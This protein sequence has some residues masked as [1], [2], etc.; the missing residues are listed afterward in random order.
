MKALSRFLA[1]FSLAF[2]VGFSGLIAC[3]SGTNASI[4]TL[5]L[6]ITGAG[7][8][9]IT[10]NTGGIDCSSSESSCTADFEENTLVTLTATPEAGYIFKGWSGANCSGAGTCE[11]TMS[12]AT[13]INAVFTMVLF[14]SNT[15]LNGDPTDTP[16]PYNIWTMKTDGSNLQHVT[17]VTA[18]GVAADFPV[19]SP[20]GEQIVF[21]SNY[22]LDNPTSGTINVAYNIWTV[23]NDGSNLSPLTLSTT[24]FANA[25]KPEWSPDGEQITF[26]ASFN[27]DNPSS[28]TINDS[29]NIWVINSDGSEL[30]HLTNTDLTGADANRP[31]WSPDGGQIVFDATFNLS[32][33]VSGTPNSDSNIW[34]VNN[35]GNSLSALTTINISGAE[36]FEPQWSPDGT[37]IIFSSN[38]NLSAPT[39]GSPNAGTNIWIMDADGSS[40][41]AVTESTASVDAIDSAWSP[42]GEQIVFASNFNLSAPTTGPA[43]SNSNIWIVNADG[44]GLSALTTTDITSA[45]A[46][47]PIYLPDQSQILF[48]SYF[49]LNDPVSGIDNS[50]NN[51]W[52]VDADGSDLNSLTESSVAGSYDPS[53]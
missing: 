49:N 17:S 4:Q 31:S 30:T 34:V 38:F 5:T 36:A 45:E 32:D 16:S 25:G 7:I 28:G 6:N 41:A 33:P 39:I 23:N 12:A 22:N 1:V 15:N 51:I 43:N 42:D 8:G 11:V 24:P 40:L 19:W 47:N 26:S 27:L 37:Q 10:S 53:Y 44:T 13:T 50:T 35:G 21:I 46:F 14:S 9:S 3:G 29:Y 48:Y 52:I 2:A 20:D 18:S